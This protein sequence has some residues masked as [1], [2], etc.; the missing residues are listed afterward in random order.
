MRFVV[1]ILV[2]FARS[3]FSSDHPGNVF[4]V[5]ERVAIAVPPTWLGWRAIDIDGKVLGQGVA[6]QATA[7][8][9][10]LPVG[11]FEIRQR[12]GSGR[13]SA[14]VVAKTTPV[15][16]SPIAI[17]AAMSWLYSDG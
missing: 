12:D 14:A 2:V 10:Q 3:G 13:I 1:P 5:G 11:Y 4:V 15:D 17:D 6:G 8:L 9:A 16:N 7:D